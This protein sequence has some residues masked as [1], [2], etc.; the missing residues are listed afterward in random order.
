MTKLVAYGYAAKETGETNMIIRLGAAVRVLVAALVVLAGLCGFAN[1]G[2]TQTVINT[3]QDLQNI[4][5]DL[6]GSY[7]LGKD[8]DASGF[9]F[10]PIG[11]YGVCPNGSAFTG[12]LD[13]NGYTIA[14]LSI[15]TSLSQAGLFFQVGSSGTVKNLGLPNISVTPTGFSSIGGI[16]GVSAGSIT[17]SYVTGLINGVAGAAGGL[18][19][20]NDNSGH[21][22]QSYADASVTGTGTAG[23]QLGGLIGSNTGSINESYSTGAV[24]GA[25]P[26]GGSAVGGLVGYNAGPIQQSYSLSSV[27]G[28]G[29]NPVGGLVGVN[30]NTIT[31]S[32]AAGRVQGAANGSVGGLIGFA[33]LPQGV[34][35]DSYWDTKTTGQS[36]SAEEPDLQQRNSYPAP[37]PPA[38][39]QWFG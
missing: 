4:S 5:N 12:T 28:A 29:F 1:T 17:N 15:S 36:K 11:C 38:S 7:V 14:N 30:A 3:I 34:A 25:T 18:V 39:I 35:K 9:N 20:V 16:A 10:T 13:G 19:G 27:K 31:Q 37:F 8:I 26:G 2:W 32:Y 33:F 6:S 22:T 24:T 23:I 21:I